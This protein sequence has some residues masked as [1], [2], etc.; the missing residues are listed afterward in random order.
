MILSRPRLY[1]RKPLLDKKTPEVPAFITLTTSRG[2]FEL[3]Q[4]NISEAEQS[5]QQ[6]LMVLQ[7]SFGIENHPGAAAQIYLAGAYTARS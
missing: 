1:S 5:L 7:Q 3:Q 4:R 6:A 2:I